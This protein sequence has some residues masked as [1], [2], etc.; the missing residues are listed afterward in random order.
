MSE[1]RVTYGLVAVLDVELSDDEREELYD[2]LESDNM[3]VNYDGTLVYLNAFNGESWDAEF[4]NGIAMF[5]S[6]SKFCELCHKH[7]LVIQP[8]TIDVFYANWY[9]GCDSPM[10][11]MTVSEFLGD[12]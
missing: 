8:E 1:Q 9:D 4:I 7:N 6:K 2:D 3:A 5:G 12:K 11:T 10:S